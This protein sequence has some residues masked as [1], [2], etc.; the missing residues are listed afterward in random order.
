MKIRSITYFFNPGWPLDEK[1]LKKAGDF[2]ARARLDFQ[3]AGFE[4]QMTR[5]ASVPF[6]YLVPSLEVSQVVHLAQE[7]EQ[8]AK[9]QG[10]DYAAI[11]PALP[12]FPQSYRVIPEVIAATRDIFACGVMAGGAGD[13][14]LPAVRACAEV[15]QRTMPLEPGGFANLRF[16]AIANMPPGG[17]FLPAAYHAGESPAFALAIEAGDLA[18]QAVTPAASL[19]EARQSLIGA[20]EQNTQ[21]MAGVAHKLEL[22]MGVRFGGFDCSL[23][24]FPEI[25]MSFGTAMERLGLPAVGLHGSL[26][27]AA[28]FADALDRAQ[29]PRAGF[30]GLMMP[31]LEDATLALRSEQGVLTVKDLLLYSAVCG[32]GLDTVPLPGDTSAG[33]IA[34]VLLDV[35]ALAQRLNK[36]LIARLMPI[37]G[38]AAGD[39]TGFD[40]AFF[41]PGRVLGLQ[42]QPLSGL[43]AGEETFDLH[44]RRSR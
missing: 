14:Y 27:A 13:I 18:V 22:E 10:F 42:A 7:L 8:A 24:P 17:P 26:A 29:F 40:F 23:A 28:F 20:L 1:A 34:A 19:A 31:V 43:L 15:I 5:L 32:A 12:E 25:E 3:A 6:P 35:A 39:P 21:R 37:P 4:V 36:P 9:A 38:K 16:G 11:G 41:A 44:P 33:Q 30:N 2:T